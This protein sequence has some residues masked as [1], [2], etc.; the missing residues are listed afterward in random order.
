MFP[1]LPE[2]LPAPPI[3]AGPIINW[4]TVTTHKIA[5]AIQT[6]PLNKAPGPISI[7]FLLLQKADQAAPG[8]FNI[9]YPRLVEHGYH[10]LC[11]IQA[12]G[13]ILKKPNKPDYTAPKAYRIIALLNCLGKISE[14]IIATKLYFLAETSDLLHKE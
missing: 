9:L 5:T 1:R 3:S 4:P 7:P 14:K 11:W 6:S 13:A 12:T 2:A 10:P 8:L